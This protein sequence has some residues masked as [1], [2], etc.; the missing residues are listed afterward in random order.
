MLLL[1]FLLIV[2]VEIESSNSEIGNK[3]DSFALEYWE[4]SVMNATDAV[5]VLSLLLRTCF[6]EWIHL[7]IKIVLSEDMRIGNGALH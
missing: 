2:L 3:D 6:D 5:A 7:K 1:F 4:K